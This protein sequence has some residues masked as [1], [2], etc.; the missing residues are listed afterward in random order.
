MSTN[1]TIAEQL[2]E[3][4]QLLDLL[5]ENGFKVNAHAKAARVVGDYAGDIGAV[6]AD[7]AAL[8]KI[9]G[10]GEK[11]ADKIIESVKTGQMSELNELR[12]KV[13]AGLIV[14]LK[15]PGL[16]PKTVRA[17]WQTLGIASIEGL[18]KSIADGSLLTLPRMGEKAVEKIKTSLAFAKGNAEQPRLPIG[19]AWPIADAMLERVRGLPGV[20]RAEMAG[21]L[22]RGRETVGDLDM[23]VGM[24]PGQERGAAQVAKVFC[25]SPGVAQVLA[26]GDTKCSVLLSVSSDMGRWKPSQDDRILGPTVQFDLRIVPAA[27]FGSALMYFT[28][29]KEHNVAMRERALKR[30]LTLSEWGLFPHE[31]KEEKPPHVRGVTPVASATEEQVFVALGL[32]WIPP[33][34]REDRGEFEREWSSADVRL[35]EIGDV[36]AELHSHTTASDGVMSIEELATRYAE[37][38]F[39]T[40]AVTDHSQS[41][42]IAGGLKPERLRAHI[43]AVRE[44]N[45]TVG[46]KLGIAIL[47][48]SEVDI[49]ADGT[50]DYEDDLLRELDVVVASPHAAL[51]QDSA[52]ATAR[53]LKAIRHPLVHI[54]GH[55]TGRLINR[56]PGLSPD[57]TAL[58]AAARESNVAL[59][60]N[61]HWLRLDLRDTHVRQAVVNGNLIA[62]DCDTHVPEDMNYLPYGV[63]TA[64]RGWLRAEQ[65]VNAWDRARLHG[66]LKSKR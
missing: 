15:I 29:S 27:S 52:T 1:E 51:T 22:R 6:A 54:V 39:H 50:L 26:S 13:P 57:M 63:A 14:V 49:L 37:R 12:G 45:A 44:A 46:K 48:G 36:K 43:A 60:I 66:W 59:E 40:V 34:A 42:A 2:E 58:I 17:M 3:I 28:G 32:P 65:C 35:L 11:I 30:G 47:A 10:I 25:E 9:D 31:P 5:G 8:L 24:E 23:L 7:K 33:E 53:L 19:K 18:E 64:R 62:I 38:G 55:P 4:A 61:S 41:S 20:A 16:G 21:S 56:R